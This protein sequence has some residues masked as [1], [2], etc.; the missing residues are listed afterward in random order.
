MPTRPHGAS[1][2]TSA[3]LVHH[4]SCIRNC[5]AFQKKKTAKRFNRKQTTT[6]IGRH[7]KTL[8]ATHQ[9]Q[10]K[11]T[12]TH[13]RVDDAIRS[14]SCL[15]HLPQDRHGLLPL[16]S[17]PARRQS[18][19]EAARVGLQP[20]RRHLPEQG[21]SLVGVA[22]PV[23]GRRGRPDDM[24]DECHTAVARGTYIKNIGTGLEREKKSL[25][26]IGGRK[27]SLIHCPST[28]DVCPQDV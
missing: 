15:V 20:R 9:Q 11:N 8:N 18:V 24:M 26:K 4:K 23:L 2:N 17:V 13:E 28:Q 5:C 19:R 12:P 16:P 1:A 25:T 27:N 10:Q 6:N 7:A 14:H 3:K 22:P 21:R